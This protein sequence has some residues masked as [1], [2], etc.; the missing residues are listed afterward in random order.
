VDADLSQLKFT[1]VSNTGLFLG[2]KPTK[3]N[4][5]AETQ[6]NLLLQ[7]NVFALYIYILL[8]LPASK[9]TSLNTA[10]STNNIRTENTGGS[11]KSVDP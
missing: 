4:F 3:K 5:T 2:G 8:K 10:I 1:I 9:I 6:S 11:N 7:T